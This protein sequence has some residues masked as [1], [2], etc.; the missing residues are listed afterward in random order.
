VNRTEAEQ[1]GFDYLD[2]TPSSRQAAQDRTLLARDNLHPS[3][4][5]YAA[6][7]R[8]ALPIVCQALGGG[9]AV[10]TDR[11]ASAPGETDKPSDLGLGGKEKVLRD[12][13]TRTLQGD[14]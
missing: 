8:L 9:G 3:G 4:Q 10:P 6:W 7:A 2:I 14:R 13:K 12:L 5:M 11:P 1:R